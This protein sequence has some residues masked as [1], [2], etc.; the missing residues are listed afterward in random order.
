MKTSL[1]ALRAENAQLQAKLAEANDF[2]K[3]VSGGA[4]SSLEAQTLKLQ[5]EMKDE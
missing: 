1:A 5:L 4:S 3:S 2:L